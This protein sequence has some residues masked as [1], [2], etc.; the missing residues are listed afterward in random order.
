MVFN[1]LFEGE[2]PAIDSG[3]RVIS[4]GTVALGFAIFRTEP[5]YVATDN[6]WLEQG[7]ASRT[8]GSSCIAGWRIECFWEEVKL[9][10][11]Y[12]SF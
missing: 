9:L 7:R 4:V 3:L 11:H 2:P 12:C 1:Q 6:L 10:R 8:L 5:F